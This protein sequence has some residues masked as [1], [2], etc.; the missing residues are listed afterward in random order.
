MVASGM[1]CDVRDII[2]QE[3]LPPPGALAERLNKRGHAVTI[4]FANLVIRRL[5]VENEMKATQFSP[6]EL[7]A[8]KAMTPLQ[9]AFMLAV[10]ELQDAY[11]DRYLSIQ[12]ISRRFEKKE[13]WAFAMAR[14]F[15]RDGLKFLVQ[16]SATV[17]RPTAKGWAAIEVLRNMEATH[18]TD[19]SPSSLAA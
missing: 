8:I 16:G 15:A 9:R 19:T 13:S 11:F 2:S 10:A 18:T 12:M 7:K 17:C 14:M 3:G 5:L 1:F 6:R 4:A